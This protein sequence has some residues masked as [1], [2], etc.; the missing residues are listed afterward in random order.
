MLKRIIQTIYPATCILCGASGAGDR[1]LCHACE[2]DIVE[3]RSA[4]C[5]CA[6][7][8]PDTVNQQFCGQCL[9]K[10]PVYDAAWSPLLYAQPLEWMIQQVKFNSRLSFTRVLS[11]LLIARLPQ[12]E[13][14]PDCIIPV[15]LHARRLTERGFNQSLEVIR[16]VAKYLNIPVDH[17]SCRRKKHSQPQSGMNARQRRQNIK[18]VFEFDNRMGYQ[19]IVIFDDVITTGS[20]VNELA[21]VIKR[22]GVKRV[23]V[24]ALARADKNYSV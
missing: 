24:W 18:D 12:I 1:D 19:Y 20:T 22:Q 6:I 23:D 11:D 14:L 16:P 2:A 15:P 8:L 5:T 4:C 21:R 9:Q 10:P 3:N 13:V 17:K 7:P